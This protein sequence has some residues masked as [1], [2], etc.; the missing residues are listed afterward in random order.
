ML[1]NMITNPA[2]AP[3]VNPPAW[4]ARLCRGVAV[5]LL[6][7]LLLALPAVVQAQYN[8]TTNNNQIRITRYTGSDSVLIIPNA[9]NGLPVTAIGDF[10]FQYRTGLTSVAVPDSVTTIGAVA[11][12]EC[13][14]LTSVTIPNSVTSIGERAFQYCDGLTSVTIPN[15]V[16]TI[17]GGA[18]YGCTKLTSVTIGNRVTT[19]TGRIGKRGFGT[20]EN[21]TSLTRVSIPSSVTTIEGYAF[22]GCTN[23]G[24]V[25]FQGNAPS[26]SSLVFSGANT[27]VYYLPGTTG[28]G[29][30]FAGR[31]TVLWNSQIQTGDAGFG[32]KAGQFGFNVTGTSGLSFVVEATTDLAQPVWTPVSTN[33]LAAGTAAF[34]DPQWRNYPTR[35]YRLR[36][37]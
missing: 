9:I 13:T 20:F 5:P 6:L 1:K 10:A 11:F 32:V 33:T 4:T 23:F 14:G 2:L 15:S 21:C 25:Y 22:S 12:L 30:T 24:S 16:T 19:I 35:F 26:G 29:A 3:H 28:W 31:P 36:T 8:Y 17:G 34:S 27:T 18:F 37:P 7:W